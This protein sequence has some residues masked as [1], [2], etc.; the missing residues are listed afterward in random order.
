MKFPLKK[1]IKERN[2]KYL[3]RHYHKVKLNYHQ[4]FRYMNLDEIIAN[5]PDTVKGHK[6][7]EELTVLFYISGLCSTS[8]AANLL[9][10]S[11]R[12]FIDILIQKDRTMDGIWIVAK[13]VYN[14]YMRHLERD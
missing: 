13:R 12:E 14:V 4:R 6:I 3:Q 10:K 2:R 1:R 5:L 7:A 9:N 11:V 8:R